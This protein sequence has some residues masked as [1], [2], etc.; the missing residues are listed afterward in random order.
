V[1]IS[2]GG[3]YRDPDGTL[4]PITDQNRSLATDANDRMAG[5]GERVMVV[6]Q[7]DL[8]LLAMVGIVDPPRSEARAAIAECRDAG[9]RVRMITG[10]HATTA[11]AIAGELGIQGRAVTGA[12]LG[13]SGAGDPRRAVP[14][15]PARAGECWHGESSA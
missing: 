1:L 11:G 6:A 7:R 15:L 13:L 2:R 5:G 9:I 8:T 14:R 3:S 10:D 4:V 12:E